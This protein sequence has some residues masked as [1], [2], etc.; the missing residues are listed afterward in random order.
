MQDLEI[1]Y[2]DHHIVAVGKPARVPTAS[3]KSGDESLL[4]MV[5]RWNSN[6]QVEGKKGYCVPI[7]FLDRPVSG[8]V[9]FAVSSKAATRLNEQFRQRTIK[10]TY[11]AA[12]NGRPAKQSDTLEHWLS[13]D[14]DE[15][16]SH[17]VGDKHPEA[18]KCVLHYSTLSVAE[19]VTLLEVNPITGRSHQIRAQLAAIGCP[20]VGDTK[21]GA[22][23]AWDGRVA[24]HALTL[25]FV[26]PVGSKPMTLSAKIP[27]YWREIC[28]GR[29]SEL[30]SLG[31]LHRG[32][33]K[34]GF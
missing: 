25:S 9:L 33:S 17:V 8:I 34:D 3:E 32:G 7:H 6:R 20:L 21:Y 24:L 4:D 15:N 30:Q 18:K 26:H 31:A 14:H 11:I 16:Y 10:K 2:E 29:V 22:E 28:P 23:I 5:R 12:T 1:I 27:D 19:T 13:K